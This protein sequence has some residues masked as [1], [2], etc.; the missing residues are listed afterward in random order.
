MGD[1]SVNVIRCPSRPHHGWAIHHPSSKTFI[2]LGTKRGIAS[3]VQ[4]SSLQS[5]TARANPSEC[6][7]HLF[8]NSSIDPS[9]TW[10]C[11]L[12]QSTSVLVQRLQAHLSVLLGLEP[13]HQ[14]YQPVPDTA[15]PIHARACRE[16]RLTHLIRKTRL[17][18][19]CHLNLRKNPPHACLAAM[20]S[21]GR[22]Q[23]NQLEQGWC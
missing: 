20:L 15:I 1:T 22:L 18:L 3:I 8:R 11:S 7:T 10:A 2:A 6:Q 14:T 23:E 4:R 16:Q 5:C 12:A 19:F 13:V 21:R 9:R 17:I